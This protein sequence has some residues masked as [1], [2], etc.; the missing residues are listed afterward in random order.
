MTM[1]RSAASATIEYPEVSVDDTRRDDLL[2]LIAVHVRLVA[3]WPGSQRFQKAC[4][5]VQT[6]RPSHSNERMQVASMRHGHGVPVTPSSANA[7]R[8]GQQQ[9]DGE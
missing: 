1:A 6:D 8:Y 3:H 5:R 4:P 9:L 2:E 7:G